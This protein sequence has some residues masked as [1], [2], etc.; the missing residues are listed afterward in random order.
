MFDWYFRATPCIYAYL[1]CTVPSVWIMEYKAYEKRMVAKE[2]NQTFTSSCTHGISGIRDSFTDVEVSNKVAHT[3][4]AFA[5]QRTFSDINIIYL[6]SGSMFS[7]L[8][9]GW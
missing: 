6:N 9:I 5:V 1:I 8:V 2:A 4:C 3:A 7:I